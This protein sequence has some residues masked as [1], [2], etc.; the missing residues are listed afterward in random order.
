MSDTESDDFGRKMADASK[1]SVFRHTLSLPTDCHDR[2]R[3]R[4]ELYNAYNVRG[5]V[6]GFG[7]DGSGRSFRLRDPHIKYHHFHIYLH[8][9]VLIFAP[10]NYGGTLSSL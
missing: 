6:G 4:A 3:K 7:G 9:H 5:V 2:A 10:N 8:F 1:P